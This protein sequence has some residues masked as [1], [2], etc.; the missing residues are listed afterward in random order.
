M[1]NWV[2]YLISALATVGE[3][4]LV[5]VLQ[6]IHDK[7]LKLYRVII[8]DVDYALS[9]GQIAATKTKTTIDDDLVKAAQGILNASATK[10]G[11]TL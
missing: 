10:N 3:Q 5:D 6:V 11:I 7:N 4:P 1:N 9:E 8:Y 2:D